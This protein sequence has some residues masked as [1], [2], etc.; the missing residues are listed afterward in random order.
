MS[1]YKEYFIDNKKNILIPALQRDYVQGERPDIIKPFIDELLL[2]LKDKQKKVDLNYIYGSEENTNDF[3]PIDGQQRLITLWLLHLYIFT[4]QNKAYNVGLHFY[5]REFANEF[6]IKLLEKFTSISNKSLLRKEIIDSAWFVKGW[7]YDKTVN[8]MLSTLEFIAEACDNPNEYI[9]YEN[10]TFSFLNMR[11]KG[12][13]DDI[14]VKMNGRGRPLSYYENLKSWMDERV[15]TLFAETPA[16]YENWQ[17]KM[18]NEWTDFFWSNRNKEQEHQEEIDDEQERFLFNLLRI[19]WIKKGKKGFV[20]DNSKRDSLCKLLNIKAPTKLEENILAIISEPSNFTLPL[21]VIDNLDLFSKEFFEWAMKVFDGLYEIYQDINNEKIE[22]DFDT[23]KTTKIY[24]IFFNNE[25]RQL[26]ISSAILDYIVYC[27]EK[28]L[29]DWLRFTR[30]II[31]NI[32]DVSDSDNRLKNILLS[33]E[34]MAKTC[35]SHQSCLSFIR[36]IEKDRYTGVSIKALDGEKKKASLIINNEKIW[37]KRIETLENNKYFTGQI[38]FI[39]DFL[40]DAPKEDRF[41]LYS[42]IMYQLFSGSGKNGRYF[43]SDID[44]NVFSRAL[45]CFTTDHSYGYPINSNWSFLKSSKTDKN[46]WKN[47]INDN[48][49]VGTEELPHNDALKQLLDNLIQ[50][51]KSKPS[52]ESFEEIIKNNKNKLKDWRRFFIDYPEVWTYF[53]KTE[54]F[55][56]WYDEYNVGLVKSIQYG[57]KVYHAE[58][59]SYC[60]YLDYK[61]HSS[62][63]DWSFGFYEQEHT[64]LY[65]EKDISDKIITIDAFFNTKGKSEDSYTLEVFLRP[66]DDE[67][68]KQW[69]SRSKEYIK[70][71]INKDFVLSNRGYTL[72]NYC[73]KAQIKK[74]IN[75]LLETK[76]K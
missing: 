5:S 10:I 32:D 67:S 50:N 60:L 47:Y 8:N 15:T 36:N 70:K 73:S 28:D 3:V 13:T 63:K 34:S 9:Y 31:C 24:K 49:I 39:F 74:I 26:L 68:D 1:S 48:D 27:K 6:S 76:F 20:I 18:D 42:K 75:N 54:K 12:L 21:Y 52:T 43:S 45:L 44:E 72:K 66:F 7:Q 37:R 46:I 4:K 17:K 61:R 25:N 55:I 51:Y 59:R 64:C 35:S 19:F 58:L 11:T 65:F 23:A 40:G 2:S 56:R 14:Y 33:F 57:G 30:N 16:F 53:N 22:F 29:H 41:D 62:I 71:Y 69:K 38:K